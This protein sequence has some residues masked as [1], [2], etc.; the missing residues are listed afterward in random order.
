MLNSYI[1]VKDTKQVEKLSVMEE[2]LDRGKQGPNTSSWTF[3]NF[4]M[5][6]KDP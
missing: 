2:Q 4:S 3:Q 6:L 5:T 1:R